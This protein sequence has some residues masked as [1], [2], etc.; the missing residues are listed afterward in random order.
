VIAN[1]EKDIFTGDIL[2]MY[3]LTFS[4]SIVAAI[5]ISTTKQKDL[6]YPISID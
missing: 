5:I 4:D 2:I 6:D 1:T 3:F